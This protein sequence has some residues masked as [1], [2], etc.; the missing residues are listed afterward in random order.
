M[1]TPVTCTWPDRFCRGA[2]ADLPLEVVAPGHLSAVRL[3]RE[4]VLG[5]RGQLDDSAASRDRVH[6]PGCRGAGEHDA[7]LAVVV[8]AP[9][10][11]RAVECTRPLDPLE[12]HI[13][14][15]GHRA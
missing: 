6:R 9:A 3:Q 14:R 15:I 12:S 7:Q 1:V 5:A 2:V 4:H 8:A 10:P 13:Y 11:D